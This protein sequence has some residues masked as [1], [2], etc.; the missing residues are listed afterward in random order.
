MTNYFKAEIIIS[1]IE[2][3]HTTKTIVRKVR[4]AINEVLDQCE[5]LA[6]NELT[7]TSGELKELEKE[8]QND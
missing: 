5:G 2:E 1:D 8:D 3:F 6:M 7:V 4:D